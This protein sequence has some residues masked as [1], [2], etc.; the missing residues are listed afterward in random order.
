MVTHT[1]AST[2]MR[3]SNG[4]TQ[5]SGCRGPSRLK[6][7]AAE[8][9]TPLCGTE[10]NGSLFPASRARS[11]RFHFVVPVILSRCGRRPQHRYPLGLTCLAPLGFV[12]ELLVVK[13]KLFPSRENEITPTVDT[14]EHLVLKFHRGWLPSARFRAPT[15]G[16]RTAVEHRKCRSSCSPSTLPLDSAHHALEE[17]VGQT[18]RICREIEV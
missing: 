15:R 6:A 2:L 7:L 8:D 18:H 9:G 12:L 5:L 16:E 3:S 11:L 14:L 13:E 17:C 1:P 10:R 4:T